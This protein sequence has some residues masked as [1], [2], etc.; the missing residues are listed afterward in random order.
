M[1]PRESCWR[2]CRHI[3]WR[4]VGFGR[5]LFHGLA[6]AVVG[7]LRIPPWRYR[8]L[9]LGESIQLQGTAKTSTKMAKNTSAFEQFRHRRN[10]SPNLDSPSY[11]GIQTNKIRC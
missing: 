8:R 2:A 10:T 3:D 6:V 11:K 5:M 9:G 1:A 4:H 7:L